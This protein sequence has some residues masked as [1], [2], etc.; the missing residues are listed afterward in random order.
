M[1]MQE[2]LISVG[3][4]AEALSV[5]ESWVYSRTRLNAIPVV[6]VG[7]YCRFRLSEVLEALTAERPGGRSEGRQHD[8]RHR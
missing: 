3:Q 5:P 7:K 6:R 8:G 2:Q 4:L 1:E